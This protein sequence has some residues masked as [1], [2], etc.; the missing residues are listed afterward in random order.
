[1]IV[2]LAA[3]VAATVSVDALP[4]FTV[5]G[6]AEI[7]TVGVVDAAPTVTTTVAVACPLAPDAVAV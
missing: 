5:V 1:V 3:L 7:V 4:A 2:T 6:L